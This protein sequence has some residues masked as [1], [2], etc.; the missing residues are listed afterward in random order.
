MGLSA[1][2]TVTCE[3]WNCDCQPFHSSSFDE[4]EAREQAIQ[5]GWHYRASDDTDWSPAHT[6]IREGQE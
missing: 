3:G 5:A 6:M 2:Y 4:T 1:T